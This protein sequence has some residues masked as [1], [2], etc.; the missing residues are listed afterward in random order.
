[1]SGMILTD[2][3]ALI[4]L[5]P[6]GVD[7]ESRPALLLRDEVQEEK[8]AFRFFEARFKDLLG[9][10]KPRKAGEIPSW[11]RSSLHADERA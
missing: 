1:M 8:Q 5:L 6:Y 4:E 2:T 9:S 10:A 11:Y 7:Q 3:F